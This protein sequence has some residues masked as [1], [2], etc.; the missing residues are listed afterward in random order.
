MDKRGQGLSLNV[1]IVAALALIVLVVLV[2]VFTGR[3]GVFQQ[4]LG[5]AADS[6]LR[7]TRALYGEC[8][9]NAA[10]ESAFSTAYNEA[11]A[12]EDAALSAQGMAEAKDKLNSDVSR[13]RGF[14]SKDS[15]D[16]DQFCRWG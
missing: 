13:C 2:L 9:P 11:D 1:I 14:T 10:A 8:H 5:G 3:I 7:A 15:C 12:L 16:T 4:G 6:E